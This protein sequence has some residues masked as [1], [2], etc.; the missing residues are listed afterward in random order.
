[1]SVRIQN[2][3]LSLTARRHLQGSLSGISDSVRRLSSGERLNL[4]SDDPAALNISERFRAQ[5]ASIQQ[6]ERNAQTAINLIQTADGALQVIDEKLIRMRS[7]AVQASN[8]ILSDDD[9]RAL[10]LEF[11]N[12]R[13]EISRIAN[14]T[15]YNGFYP[16][17]PGLVERAPSIEAAGNITV[18]TTPVDLTLWDNGV[19]DG[20]MVRLELNGEVVE[21]SITLQT[22]PGTTIQLGLLTGDN[23]LE[24]TALNEGDLPPNTATFRVSD[25]VD[26]PQ[27]QRWGLNSGE[28]IV[29]NL[30]LDQA[31]EEEIEAEP[32]PPPLPEPIK[33]H[34]GTENVRDV[35]YYYVDRQNATAEAL[36]LLDIDLLTTTA[37][38]AAIGRID[39]AIVSKDD[40][41]TRL[42][43]YVNRLQNTILNLGISLESSVKAESQIRDTDI[44]EEMTNFTRSQILAQTGLAMVT[45][46]NMIPN[47]VAQL[48]G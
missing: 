42:G 48:L 3:V 22:P 9:R 1:M 26:G 30:H 14:S 46:A 29:Y 2:N 45:Q 21:E 12:L 44:A 28:S 32:E 5:I 11:D 47:M 6:A 37:A 23:Q 15:N 39:A 33:F 20:D 38:Q 19:F 18:N 27:Q 34:I 24:I 16:I 13:S 41:R 36:G 35:D 40:V 7:L 4:A 43:S 17:S 31:A 10:Q 25:V 8:G